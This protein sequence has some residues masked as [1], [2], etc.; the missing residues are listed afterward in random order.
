MSTPIESTPAAPPAV[1]PAPDNDTLRMGMEI[2]WREHQH[3]RDQTWKSVQLVALVAVGLVTADAHLQTK[4]AT[5]TQS[6]VSTVVT[7]LLVVSLGY[8]GARLGV[9]HRNYQIEK[10][11]EIRQCEHRLGLFG[12]VVPTATRRPTSLTIGSAFSRNKN[13]GAFLLRIQVALMFFGA[14]YTILR[15]YFRLSP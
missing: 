2:A 12:T 13:T 1:P 10:F 4:A 8:F 5:L 7:G 14:L 15:I 11:D 9:H 3:V 6:T